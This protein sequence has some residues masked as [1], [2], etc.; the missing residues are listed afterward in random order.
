[1]AARSEYTVQVDGLKELQRSMRA[2]RDKELNKAVRG[3]NK[4][5]ADV[6][7][8][9]AKR[10]AP[11]GRKTSRDSKTYR[12]GK[13]ARS[14]GV[15]AS[16]KGAAIKAGSAGR[17]PYAAAIHFG[18]PKRNIRPNRFLYRAMART[19][20]DVSDVYETA[21]TQVMRDHLES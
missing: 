1:M 17:V 11:E 18:F 4:A 3:A 13:L 5:A 19:S 15:V 21:I 2:L 9:M 10:V 16:A 12:P 6:V 20:D 7:A 8:P 14:I